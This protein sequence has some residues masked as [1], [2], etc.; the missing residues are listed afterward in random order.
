[1]AADTTTMHVGTFVPQGW[2]LDLRA[3][4][5]AAAKWETVRARAQE[6]EALAYDS[7]WVYDHFHTFPRTLVEA[8]FEC[9][10]LMAAL[11]QITT[12]ARLGQLV[13]CQGYRNP[14]YLAKMAA[15]VDVMSGGRVEVG[16]GAG[17]FEAEHAAYGYPFPRIRERLDRMAEA[18]QILRRM[19]TEERASFA[20]RYYTV[21]GAINEPKP[22][23]HPHPRLWI[24]GTGE[25]VLLRAVAAHA[26]GWNYNRAPADF[27]HKRDVLRRHC[28]AV[29]RDP[30]AITISVERMGVCLDDAG[31]LA[32]WLRR[33]LPAEIPVERYVESYARSQCVGTAEDCFRDLAFFAERGVRFFILY[34]PDGA[35][36]EMARRF[37]KQVLPRLRSTFG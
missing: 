18:A 35:R 3:I 24:G 20:G 22:L 7:L 10:T 19:W 27:D 36:G 29:G 25:K 11:S 4:E 5:G 30:A 17:W 13:T 14:A 16:L 23:Q 37:A 34:F 8:T 21:N 1:M 9:W 28:D 31:G 32:D 2:R 15:C 26:D 12:R 6:L 33:A